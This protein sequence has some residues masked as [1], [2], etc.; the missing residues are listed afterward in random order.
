MDVDKYPSPEDVERFA[1]SVLDMLKNIPEVQFGLDSDGTLCTSSNVSDFHYL[2]VVRGPAG[3][4]SRPLVVR[5]I[6]EQ[7]SKGIIQVS[8]YMSD[9]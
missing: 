9:R 4:D 5:Y 3:H 7:L 6:M 2:G 1:D 8:D